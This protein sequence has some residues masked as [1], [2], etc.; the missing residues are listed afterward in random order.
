MKWAAILNCNTNRHFLKLSS[1]QRILRENVSS[2]LNWSF[3][4]TF[5]DFS[6]QNSLRESRQLSES[7]IIRQFFMKKDNCYEMYRFL[8]SNETAALSDSGRNCYRNN[9]ILLVMDLSLGSL[10]LP[11]IV[12]M[13]FGWVKRV[14]F[15]DFC[16]EFFESYLDWFMGW[17]AGFKFNANLTK[18][19]GKF[20]LSLLALWRGKFIEGVLF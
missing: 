5:I 6:S 8:L 13:N 1:F 3:V 7:S 17:P 18:F 4:R 2:V 15:Q 10:L 16:I 14:F 11:L 20:F 12:Q 9:L 19:L